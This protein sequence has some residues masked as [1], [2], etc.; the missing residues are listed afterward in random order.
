MEFNTLKG[1]NNFKEAAG[2]IHDTFVSDSGQEKLFN[3]PKVVRQE[4]AET[5]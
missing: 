3:I 5:D 2:V 4:A 1:E